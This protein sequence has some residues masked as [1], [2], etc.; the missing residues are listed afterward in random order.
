MFIFFSCNTRTSK[1]KRLTRETFIEIKKLFK[2]DGI[3]IDK[4]LVSKEEPYGKKKSF[5]YYIGCDNHDYFG[6][7]CINPLR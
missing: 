3:D 1:K 5:K 7:L 4:I 6:P 2:I